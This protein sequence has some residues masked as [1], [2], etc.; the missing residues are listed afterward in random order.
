[1]L[2]NMNLMMM[3]QEAGPTLPIFFSNDQKQLVIIVDMQQVFLK[4][5][6]N[7]LS[8]FDWTVSLELKAIIWRKI[9]IK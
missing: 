4:I 1:M 8:N 7:L 3:H 2:T 6:K 5:G 9:I